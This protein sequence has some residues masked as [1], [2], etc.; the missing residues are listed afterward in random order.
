MGGAIFVTAA[1]SEIFKTLMHRGID[2]QIYFWRTSAGTEIDIIV[3][4][5]QRLV[6][7]EIKLSSTPRP[8][9]ALNI[10]TFQKDFGEKE[11][12]GY[13]LNTGD[14]RLPLG[15]GITALPFRD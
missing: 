2:P 12:P 11:A 8:A 15:P 3:E 10:K 9:M 7:I 6:P 14:V 1:I 4:F 13:V 5:H